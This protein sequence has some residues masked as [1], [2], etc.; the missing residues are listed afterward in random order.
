MRATFKLVTGDEIILG[1][2]LSVKS[3]KKL[4]ATSKKKMLADSKRC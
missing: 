2:I 3:E 4:V 1:V